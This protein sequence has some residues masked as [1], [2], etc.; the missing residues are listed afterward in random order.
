MQHYYKYEVRF[1]IDLH[2]SLNLLS[3]LIS[4]CEPSAMCMIHLLNN[5]RILQGIP[6]LYSDCNINVIYS[7]GDNVGQN[8]NGLEN[9]DL[10]WHH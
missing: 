5:L 4:K 6:Y 1:Y 9:N 7:S 2:I 10:T 8:I 3:D